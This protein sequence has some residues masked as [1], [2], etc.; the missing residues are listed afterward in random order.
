MPVNRARYV[1]ALIPFISLLCLLSCGL[2]DVPYISYIPDGTIT[3]NTSVR[4]W[5]PSNASEGYENPPVGYFAR[6][7][8]YYRIYISGEQFSGLINTSTLRS[9]INSSLSSDFESLRSLTDKT[10][11]SNLPSNL[12]T[13]FSNRRYFKLTLEETNI[14]ALLGR[15][16][17]GQALEI[18]F[19]T[20]NGEIP[21]LTLNGVS[22]R[23]R[24]AVSGP[25]LNFNPRPENRYFQNH[26]DL[27]NRANVTNNIN[28]D[29]ATNSRTT[30]ELRFTWASMYIFAVGKDYLST[31]YSQPTHLGIFFLTSAN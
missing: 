27:F 1:A 10:S 28:A 15:G 16:S 8:I 21:V 30:P 5:L 19:P 24:R 7:E 3:D 17:L 11:T 26:P 13:T 9:Q 12:D 6:F 20:V 4:I 25:G 23:L 29:V 18:R 31:I 2:E 22:Y 14:D